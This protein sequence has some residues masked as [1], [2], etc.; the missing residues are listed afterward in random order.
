M[1]RSLKNSAEWNKPESG[2]VEVSV[3]LEREVR[4]LND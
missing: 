4:A 2:S 3:V 1:K